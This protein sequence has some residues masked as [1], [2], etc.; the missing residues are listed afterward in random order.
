MTATATTPGEHGPDEEL[1]KARRRVLRV[2]L[3]GPR[4]GMTAWGD[5]GIQAHLPGRQQALLERVLWDL[6]EEGMVT[7]TETVYRGRSGLRWAL[8]DPLSVVR[9][10]QSQ[11]RD[12]SGRWVRDGNGNDEHDDL[13]ATA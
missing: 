11:R 1:E 10:Q 12:S 6:Q 13:S 4:E 3:D 5:D 7:A 9:E 8:T 2:L